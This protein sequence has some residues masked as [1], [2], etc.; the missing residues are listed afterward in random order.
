MAF[1]RASHS[2]EA[3]AR[4]NGLSKVSRRTG[5]GDPAEA[6]MRM[7]ESEAV[8]TV[9]LGRR[10]HGQ[11]MGLVLGSVSQKVVSLAPCI[12]IVVP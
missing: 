7:I 10:G 1:Y 4:Q 2:A 5:W 9:V 12:V 11:L 3:R 8:D 6:I